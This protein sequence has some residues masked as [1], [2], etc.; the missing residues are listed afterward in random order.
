[1]KPNEI[2]AQLK[3]HQKIFIGHFAGVPEKE[4]TWRPYPEHWNLLEI[5][6]HLFDEEQED[7][8][9]RL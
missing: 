2:I 3:L 7:F 5:A 9:A 4:Y 1:M 6:C 8:R